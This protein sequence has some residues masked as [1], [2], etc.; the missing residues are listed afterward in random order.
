MD[1]NVALIYAENMLKRQNYDAMDYGELASAYQQHVDA[2]QRMS[3]AEKT[4]SAQTL[5]YSVAHQYC[6]GVI[7]LLLSGEAQTVEEARPF[8][9]TRGHKIA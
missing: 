9:F 3:C 1:N 6:A 4:P 2:A 5:A 8:A 7:G